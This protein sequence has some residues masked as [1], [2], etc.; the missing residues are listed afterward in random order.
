MEASNTTT[1]LSGA[2][3][4]L[5]PNHNYRY[6]FIQTVGSKERYGGGGGATWGVLFD[7]ITKLFLTKVQESMLTMVISNK[8]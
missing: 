2:L 8:W 6:Y 5:Q 7:G 1:S 4:M 3:N